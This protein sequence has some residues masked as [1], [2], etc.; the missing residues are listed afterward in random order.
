MTMLPAL[1]QF[2]LKGLG[3]AAGDRFRFTWHNTR[4]GA[5][6]WIEHRGRWRAGVVV[7]LGR[8]RAAV[9][10]EAAGF[11]RLIIEKS[12]NQLRRRR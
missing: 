9:A 3:P 4:I 2:A 12:Y 7:G 6:V 11:R 8:K 5:A 10:I 1:A